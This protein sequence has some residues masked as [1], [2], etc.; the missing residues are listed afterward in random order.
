MKRRTTMSWVFALTVTVTPA[1]AT[2]LTVTDPAGQPLA[3]VMVR[4]RPADGPQLDTSDNGY[5]APGV[6]RTVAP[7]VTRFSDASG[8]VEFAERDASMEYLVRKPG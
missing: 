4:E 7:E 6:S 1:P 8:R 5:P 3:T 2:Q